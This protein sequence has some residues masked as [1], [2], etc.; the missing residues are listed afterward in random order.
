MAI[1]SYS[2]T[3]SENMRIHVVDKSTAFLAKSLA[4]YIDNFFTAYWIN[5]LDIHEATLTVDGETATLR[6]VHSEGG[7]VTY[8][9]TSGRNKG[10]TVALTSRPSSYYAFRN[11]ARQGLPFA[12][13][14]S[15]VISYDADCSFG[16]DIGINCMIT[17]LEA[18]NNSIIREN[19]V[20]KGFQE[21]HPGEGF[22][23][24]RFDR[25]YRGY[26]P[27]CDDVE[28]IGSVKEWELDGCTGIIGGK[29][30]DAAL[31]SLNTVRE[32][33]GKIRPIY[34]KY[35]LEIDEFNYGDDE[36]TT[37]GFAYITADRLGE[38]FADLQKLIDICRS[39]NLELYGYT[40]RLISV[41]SGKP[42]MIGL[43]VG[44]DGTLKKTYNV[45]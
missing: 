6:D 33:I 35:G 3:V 11:L 44:S 37:R 28:V 1:M 41:E 18:M 38:F 32:I 5:R 29:G 24:Y 15:F 42:G 40:N 13:E 19:T 39:Y 31:R 26:A 10:K 14:V 2:V 43:S 27:E 22:E 4:Y 30:G 21:T 17:A 16:A 45:A 34:E 25:D 36:I 20:Y 8:R 7:K 9:A 12:K 23:V